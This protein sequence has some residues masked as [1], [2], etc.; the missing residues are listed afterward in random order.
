MV[1]MYVLMICVMFM[2][3]TQNG[4]HVYLY[5]MY[6]NRNPFGEAASTVASAYLVDR[7]TVG[8]QGE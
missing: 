3:M 6:V 7:P 5:Y 4:C 2:I 1:F 8:Y